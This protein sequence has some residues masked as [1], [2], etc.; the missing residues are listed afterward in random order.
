[1]IIKQR[2]IKAREMWIKYYE[3]LGSVS[4]AAR[5]CGI[6]RST[7][8]RWLNRYKAEGK[9][10]LQ[11]K[12]KR[13][14]QLA[15]QKINDHLEGL[16]KSIRTEFTFGPQR[17]RIHLLRIHNLDISAATI[18]RVLKKMRCPILKSTVSKMS[19]PATAGRFQAIGCKWMSP[20]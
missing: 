13:P 18:W 8:Y 14:K 6:P 3:E 15:R 16:V 4:K 7:L 2:Q 17:I 12:S 19:I 20:R 10:G 11:G 1:M 9:E 5:K